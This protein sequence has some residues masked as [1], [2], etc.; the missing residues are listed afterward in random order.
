MVKDKKNATK[1]KVRDKK[2]VL[3]W[4]VWVI[5][6]AII[7][8]G[9]I[10]TFIL[11]YNT[12]APKQIK[13]YDDGENIYITA[14]MNDNYLQYRFKFVGEDEE[15]IIIDSD[16][17]TLTVSELLLEG[18]VLGKSYDISVCYL[19]ENVGNNSQY[20]KSITWT[21]YTYLSS[22]QISYDEENDCINWQGIEN[23]DYY[24]VYISGLDYIKTNETNIEL[25]L[26]AGGNRTFYV[27]AYSNIDYYKNSLPSNQLNIKVIHEFLPFENVL[28]DEEEK[29]LT[30]VGSELL[31]SINVYLND[32]KYE[33]VEFTTNF[34]QG[35]YTYTIDLSLYYVEG[36]TVGASPSTQD[37]YNIY[38][39]EITYA[40]E[41]ENL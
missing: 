12:S 25:Q 28:L 11:N 38:N 5:V 4:V 14:D 6:A 19:S 23:A 13:I 29:S 9:I 39:G 18:I 35:K 1:G 37:E 33:C 8:G 36:M 41:N 3:Y 24:I 40:S 2:R 34:A 32:A 22:P 21:A 15:E 17:N 16:D 31:T 7:L 27:V 10:T 30:L 26:L 20:S